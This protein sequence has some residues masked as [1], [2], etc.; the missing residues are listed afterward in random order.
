VPGPGGFLHG[1][2]RQEFSVDDAL[3][4]A[5][6]ALHRERHAAMQAGEQGLQARLL[7]AILEIEDIREG[8]RKTPPEEFPTRRVPKQHPADT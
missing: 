7:R 5:V 3:G 4:L 8:L 2:S 6:D 1:M